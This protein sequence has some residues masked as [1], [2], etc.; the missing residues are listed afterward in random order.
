MKTNSKPSKKKT[1]IL[2]GAAAYALLVSGCATMQPVVMQADSARVN[3][4]QTDR[5]IVLC[6][7][8]ADR[9]VGRNALQ[10]AK[11]AQ[12]FGK[13]GAAEFADAAADTAVRK[14]SDVL[15]RATGAAAGGVAGVATKLLFEWN[16]SDKVHQR[17]VEYCLEKR[18]HRVLGWR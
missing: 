10:A 9:E 4:K 11:V 15:R 14:G 2:S 12:K 13:F 8:A 18:G 3:T 17:H 5:A 6:R 7:E 1:F 16:E